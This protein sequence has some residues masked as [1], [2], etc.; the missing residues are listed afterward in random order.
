M[1]NI[2]IYL[3]SRPISGGMSLCDTDISS[4]KMVVYTF[5]FQCDTGF[6]DV[7]CRAV[8][9]LAL[10]KLSMNY[11]HPKLVIVFITLTS[12]LPSKLNVAALGIAYSV[13]AMR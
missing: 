10:Y 6:N 1:K 5:D 11:F 3:N 13:R 8:A 4:V 7:A 9:S 12:L 2:Q